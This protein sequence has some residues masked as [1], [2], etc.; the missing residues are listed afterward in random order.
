MSQSYE[1]F[2]ARGREI[3]GGPVGIATV[4][5]N[6]DIALESGVYPVGPNFHLVLRPV[7]AEGVA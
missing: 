1:V 3:V 2:L 7:A 5:D 4:R 6:G